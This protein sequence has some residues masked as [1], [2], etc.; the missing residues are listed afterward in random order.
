VD[1]LG[2]AGEVRVN[3]GAGDVRDDHQRRVV[4]GLAVLA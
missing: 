1:L 4:E 3:L 2:G